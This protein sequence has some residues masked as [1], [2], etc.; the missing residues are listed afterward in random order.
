MVG[1]VP[2]KMLNLPRQYPL[3]A[4]GLGLGTVYLLWK[5]AQRS[6][7]G[8]VAAKYVADKAGG[9]DDFVSGV[10][11]TAAHCGKDASAAAKA[12]SE[13]VDRTLD[14]FADGVEQFTKAMH[15]LQQDARIGYQQVRKSHQTGT[16]P[17]PRRRRGPRSG[18]RF[19]AEGHRKKGAGSLIAKS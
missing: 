3:L 9:G 17:G 19:V 5:T 14:T 8:K 18:G 6:D 16:R 13:T 2:Q 4:G 7:P 15:D 10:Q 11:H 12:V 1:P